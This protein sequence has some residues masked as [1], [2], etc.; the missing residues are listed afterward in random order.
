M[1]LEQNKVTMVFHDSLLTQLEY[2]VC[3]IF[4]FASMLHAAAHIQPELLDAALDK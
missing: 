4:L 1:I 3:M 2:S